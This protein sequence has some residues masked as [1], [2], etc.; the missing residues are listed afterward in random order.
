MKRDPL[1]SALLVLK[2][3]KSYAEHL[4]VRRV[5]GAHY[6][7][8]SIPFF[9]Y[10]LSLH[11]SV[12]CTHKRTSAWKGLARHEAPTV[13]LARKKVAIVGPMKSEFGGELL[14]GPE[15]KDWQ[16]LFVAKVQKKSGNRTIRIAF[17][18]EAGGRHP[19]ACKLVR[20]FK[21]NRIDYE[22]NHIR[23]FAVNI[24]S[25]AERTQLVRFLEK[26][27][28]SAQMIWEDGDPEPGMSLDAR[29]LAD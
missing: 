17:K 11:D 1:L 10:N 15:D 19:E 22:F 4:W 14:V 5:V 13:R 16:P 8:W 7:L 2:G 3:L 25:A 23:L 24:T 20:F 27:P 28:K 12:T 29:V 9:A 26:I 21:R 18:A 6:E